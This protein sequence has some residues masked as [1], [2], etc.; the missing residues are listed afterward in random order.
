MRTFLF[1]AVILGIS[2]AYGVKHYSYT[3][4]DDYVRERTVRLESPD[5]SCT[6]TMVFSPLNNK[7]YT[8][9]AAHCEGLAFNG[10][11]LAETESGEEKFL[12][13]LKI[14]RNDDL[15]LLANPWDKALY[16]NPELKFHQHVR[17]IGWGMGERPFVSTGEVLRVAMLF[18]GDEYGTLTQ[19]LLT[20]VFLRPGNSGGP[21]LDDDNNLVGIDVV[22]YTD[23]QFSGEV[24][25]G[26]IQEFFKD[27][28]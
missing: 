9:T 3:H 19:H 18:V 22:G 27:V 14:D 17:A 1:L 4:S 15:M 20:T 7:L 6:G 11:I 24:T 25:P 2:A 10:K 21:L 28:K 26:V 8:L 13:I 12:T 16:L 23:S 5:G